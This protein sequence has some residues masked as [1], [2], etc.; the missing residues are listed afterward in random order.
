LLFIVKTIRDT[1]NYEQKRKCIHMIKP[2]FTIPFGDAMAT[3]ECVS[4]RSRAVWRSRKIVR[5][6]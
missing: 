6:G 3:F 4:T 1:C 2:I 5:R